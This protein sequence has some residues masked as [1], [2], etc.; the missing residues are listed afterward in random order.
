MSPSSLL[1]REHRRRRGGEA[2]EPSPL[3]TQALSKRYITPEGR[4]S[5]F[6]AIVFLKP[7][8]IGQILDFL[9]DPVEV[10]RMKGLNRTCFYYIEENQHKLIQRAVRL[11][12]MSMGQ[13]PAFWMRVVLSVSQRHAEGNSNSLPPISES[14]ASFDRKLGRRGFGAATKDGSIRENGV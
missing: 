8:V 13:R 10:S 12:G 11:G 14:D 6:E 3:E 4:P 7:K 5:P 1:D 2:N 9:G